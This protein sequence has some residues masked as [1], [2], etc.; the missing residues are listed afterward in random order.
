MCQLLC[1]RIPLLDQV[2]IP[3]RGLNAFFRLLLKGVQNINSL[4][5]LHGQDD[6]VCVRGV[7]KGNLK[8]AATHT[9]E[10]TSFG[11]PPN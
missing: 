9:F 1:F 10:R 6:P 4:P 11:I 5:N 8:N 2:N 7:S 3:L